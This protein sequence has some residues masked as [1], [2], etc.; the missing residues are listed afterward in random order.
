MPT[1]GLVVG[2]MNC[3]HCVRE[4]TARLR[5]VSGVETVT[6]G[7]ASTEVKLTGTMTV[8]DV[9]GALRGL[10]VELID[11]SGDANRTPPP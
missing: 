6:A 10:P 5:D 4:V 3:R 11:G 7:I 8:D 9:L 2:G 1:I